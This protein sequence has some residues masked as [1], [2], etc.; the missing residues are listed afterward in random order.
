MY[1]KVSHVIDSLSLRQR[2]EV[3]E[4][5]AALKTSSPLPQTPAA[6]TRPPTTLQVHLRAHVRAGNK[7]TLNISRLQDLWT[8][9]TYMFIQKVL[10]CLYISF[11]SPLMQ[12][13]V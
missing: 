11:R 9:L 5:E 7:K 13:Y 12:F 1:G 3:Q 8:Y 2:L 6:R 10:G 4:L